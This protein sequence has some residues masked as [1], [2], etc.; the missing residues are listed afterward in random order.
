MAKVLTRKEL[1]QLC[2]D[3]ELYYETIYEPDIMKVKICQYVSHKKLF[4]WQDLCCFCSLGE[5]GQIE[6]DYKHMGK[7]WRCWDGCPSQEQRKET[8]WG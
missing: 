4:R 1:D 3:D 6:V 2:R 7:R 5:C 8:P